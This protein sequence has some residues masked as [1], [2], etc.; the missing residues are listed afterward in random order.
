MVTVIGLAGLVSAI[1][2]ELGERRREL[3]ILRSAGARPLTA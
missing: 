1:L 3:A 2:V